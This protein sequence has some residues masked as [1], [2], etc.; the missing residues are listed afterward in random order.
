MLLEL[1]KAELCPFCGKD[2]KSLGRHKWRWKEKLHTTPSTTH[3]NHDNNILHRTIETPLNFLVNLN[4]NVESNYCEDHLTTYDENQQN[5]RTD[6][7]F[8][9]Y[10]GEKCKGLRGLRAHQHSSAASNF[11]DLKALF[12]ESDIKLPTTKEE[13]QTANMYFHA[14]L[15]LHSTI[16]NLENEERVFQYLRLF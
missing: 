16:T 14:N 7:D 1:N 2:F 3:G 10:C 9:C 6:N 5:K 4:N 13:R 12:R 8:T 11:D 15:D